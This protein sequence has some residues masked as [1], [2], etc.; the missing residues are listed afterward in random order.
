[1]AVPTPAAAQPPAAQST[2]ALAAAARGNPPGPDAGL[3]PA[4][5]ALPAVD[6]PNRSFPDP[7][8]GSGIRLR[9]GRSAGDGPQV[10]LSA[11]LPAQYRGAAAAL[12][13]LRRAE[14]S[15]PV[16][17]VQLFGFSGGAPVALAARSSAANP[18]AVASWRI[19]S[20]SLV[21]EE[22]VSQTG[23]VSSTRYTVRGDGTWEESW[24][25]AGVSGGTGG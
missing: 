4:V 22:R 3:G 1:A 6:W 16:D 11:V 21:R 14:G 18:Q 17:L 9:D 7:A 19:D 2:A 8:G 12:V 15:V 23:A 20:G 5:G 25:G 13:V 24:P 10:A